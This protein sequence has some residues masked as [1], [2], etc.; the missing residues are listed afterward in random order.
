MAPPF[1]YFRPV[2]LDTDEAY[3][4][5]DGSAKSGEAD[6]VPVKFAGYTACPAII[7]ISNSAGTKKRCLRDDLFVLCQ[8]SSREEN[9]MNGQTGVMETTR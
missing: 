1:R 5:R 9:V 2:T 4:L 6:L 3:Y 7:I 8:P